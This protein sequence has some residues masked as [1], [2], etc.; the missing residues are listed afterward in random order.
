MFDVHSFSFSEMPLQY[1]QLAV[2]TEFTDFY[3]CEIR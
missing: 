1:W 3:F 2:N